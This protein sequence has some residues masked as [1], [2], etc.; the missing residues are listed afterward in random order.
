MKDKILSFEQKELKK[1]YGLQKSRVSELYDL[2]GPKL[3]NHDSIAV[4]VT[5]ALKWEKR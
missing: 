1:T 2:V 4:G 3:N 5:I